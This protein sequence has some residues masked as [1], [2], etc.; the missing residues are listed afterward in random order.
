MNRKELRIIA[1]VRDKIYH[2]K[3]DLGLPV[4]FNNFEML[5]VQETMRLMKPKKE[6]E[7]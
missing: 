1:S 5:A 2:A 4:T 6:R 3:E 7:V